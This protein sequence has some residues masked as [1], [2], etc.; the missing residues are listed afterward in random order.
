MGIN[1]EIGR[2]PAEIPGWET[3]VDFKVRFNVTEENRGE[4]VG[5]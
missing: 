1:P 5:L 2:L 3:W 4:N